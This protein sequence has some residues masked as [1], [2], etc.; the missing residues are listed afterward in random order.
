MFS[1][2][3]VESLQVSMVRVLLCDLVLLGKYFPICV[4]KERIFRQA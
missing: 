1:R 3:S 2:L 4:T